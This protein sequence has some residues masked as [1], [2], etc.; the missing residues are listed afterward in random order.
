MI[1]KLLTIAGLALNVWA[2]DE[3]RVSNTETIPFVDGGTL[4]L[5]KSSGEVDIQGWDRPDVEIVITKST[6]DPKGR[7]I[8]DQVSAKAE[9][10]G[11]EIVVSAGAKKGDFRIDYLIHAP[12]TS[13][14]AIEHDVGGV[15]VTGIAGDIQANLHDGQITLWEPENGKY[16]IDAK[17]KIGEVISDFAGSDHRTHFFGDR[18]TEPAAGETRKLDLRVGFGDILILKTSY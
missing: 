18:F 12:K 7:A 11:N 10:R 15:Y 16:S 1:G 14:L 6:Y 17:C 2:A 9:R 4:R 13:R 3:I 5:E 8:L